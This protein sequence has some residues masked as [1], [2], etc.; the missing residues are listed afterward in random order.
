MSPD[1]T[2]FHIVASVNRMI[3]NDEEKTN[4]P[5]C[6]TRHGL[7]PFWLVVLSAVRMY[8]SPEINKVIHQIRLGFNNLKH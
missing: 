6:L 3:S 2:K 8:I 1:S 7:L 4:N 5:N